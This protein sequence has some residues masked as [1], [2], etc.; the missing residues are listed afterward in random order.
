MEIGNPNSISDVGVAGLCARSAIM[1]AHLNVI[2]NAKDYTNIKDRNKILE[3]AKKIEDKAIKQEE[4][5]L[6]KTLQGIKTSS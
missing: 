5:I 3:K 2:I 4:I 6:S 1:G